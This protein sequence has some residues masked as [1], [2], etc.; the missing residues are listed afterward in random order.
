MVSPLRL[1]CIAVPSYESEVF[2]P[3]RNRNIGLYGV[4]ELS[5]GAVH[6]RGAPMEQLSARAAQCGRGDYVV[7]QSLVLPDHL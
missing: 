1:R 4:E 7:H 2:C 3:S 6:T 5:V